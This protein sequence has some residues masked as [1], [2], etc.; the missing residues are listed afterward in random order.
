MDQLRAAMIDAGLKTRSEAEP[1]V[2]PKFVSEL[3][4]NQ[5]DRMPDT[6]DLMSVQ[7]LALFVTRCH[8]NSVKYGFWETSEDN[9]LDT[10]VALLHTKISAAFEAYRSS[11]AP[12][13]PMG[14][15]YYSQWQAK[16][17]DTRP[18]DG[19]EYWSLYCTVCHA[20]TVHKGPP[21][22]SCTCGW[23]AK[24]EGFLPELADLLICLGDMAGCWEWKLEDLRPIVD[25]NGSTPIARFINELHADVQSLLEVTMGPHKDDIMHISWIASYLLSRVL[26]FCDRRKL[27]IREAIA[28]KMVYNVTRPHRHGGKRV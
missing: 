1:I 11:K 23:L 16:R 13:Y 8:D 19:G 14:H 15:I 6:A 28:E 2:T 22:K 4:L 18:E 24:P 17:V 27:L 7:D 10:K 26:A 5:G 9:D 21:P 25:D 12:S 3:R 20:G